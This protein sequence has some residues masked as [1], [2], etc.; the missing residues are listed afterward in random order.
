MCEWGRGAEGGRK[1]ERERE[2][3]SSMSRGRA[4]TGRERGER[5]S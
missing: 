3:E 4:E 2:R 1:K 5:E